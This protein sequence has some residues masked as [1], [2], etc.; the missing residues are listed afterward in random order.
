MS[1]EQQLMAMGRSARDCVE[2]KAK[3][4]ALQSEAASMA[5]A[6]GALASSMK[7]VSE[8][9]DPSGVSVLPGLGPQVVAVPV[10]DRIRSI[11]NETIEELG[12]KKTLATTLKNMGLDL[13]E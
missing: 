12:K 11:A 10:S 9:T 13:K 7:I 8:M 4:S 6:L 5:T 3:L 2:C 1:D